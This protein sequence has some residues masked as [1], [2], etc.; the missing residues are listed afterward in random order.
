M[1]CTRQKIILFDKI[2]GMEIGR[3]CGTRGIE[4][5]TGFWWGKAEGKYQLEDVGVY[6]TILLGEILGEIG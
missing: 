6:R 5:N 2:K 3:S 1:F 4:E